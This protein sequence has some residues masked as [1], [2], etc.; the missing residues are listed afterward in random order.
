MTENHPASAPPPPVE[1]SRSWPL[2]LLLALGFLA[3]IGLG[4]L[5]LFDPAR[6]ALYPVC[7]FK[8]MTGYDCP[9]CGGLR[10]VHQLLRG[11]VWEAVQLN[12]MVVV[13]FPL[14]AVW[15]VRAWMRSR[16]VLRSPGKPLMVWA[17]LLILLIVLFGVVRNLPF[18]PFGVTPM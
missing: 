2:P 11:E 14:L 17:W 13:A 15:A 10:S 9:G 16:N 8:K 7:L 1:S 5:F 4:L 12:A 6:H 3:L 18:W